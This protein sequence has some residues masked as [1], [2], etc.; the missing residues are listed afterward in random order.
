MAKGK[1]V[2]VIGA[3]FDDYTPEEIRRCVDGAYDE[4]FEAEDIKEVAGMVGDKLGE[5]VE[6][7]KEE[8]AERTKA[9]E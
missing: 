9:D 1:V 3:F 7:G 5:L 2:Q 8:I 4:K 6:K